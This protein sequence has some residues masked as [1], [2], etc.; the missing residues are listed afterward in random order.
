MVATFFPHDPFP[1]KRGAHH[2]CMQV[3]TGLQELGCE[4]VLC[5]STLLSET[6]WDEARQRNL[7]A[8]R[9]GRCPSPPVAQ[10]VNT[11]FRGLL[12]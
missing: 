4:V 9:F 1:P 7:Q 8:G 11:I 5:G 12:R 2:R 10:D 6:S 3:I